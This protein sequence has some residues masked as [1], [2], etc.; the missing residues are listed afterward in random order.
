MPSKLSPSA[1]DY[2]ISLE[3]GEPRAIAERIGERGS[4]EPIKGRSDLALLRLRSASGD[5]R[6]AWEQVLDAIGDA[7][8][9][10]PV[11]LDQEGQPQYPTGEV[12]VRFH[13][14][15][16]EDELARF[17]VHHKLRLVRRNEFV[18]EQVVFEPVEKSRYLP[19]VVDELDASDRTR[20]AWANTIARY[21]RK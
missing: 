2:V 6:Q 4:V 8:D 18:P 7:T 16:S 17:A 9:V 12:S 19:D 10:Q 15:M 13:D 20:L 14:A 5:P 1:T 11:L 3:E 21:E